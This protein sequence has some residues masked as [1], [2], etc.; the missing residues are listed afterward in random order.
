MEIETEFGVKAMSIPRYVSPN[1]PLITAAL[2]SLD[3][4]FSIVTR[5]VL[6]AK[7]VHNEAELDVASEVMEETCRACQG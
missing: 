1:R 2:K 7:V 4:V 6:D 3:Q 5:T